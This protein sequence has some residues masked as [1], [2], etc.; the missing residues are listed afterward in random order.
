[1]RNFFEKA[2]NGAVS[3]VN[4]VLPALVF[5]VVTFI[6][7]GM[8][9]SIYRASEMERRAKFEVVAGDAADRIVNRF[10][11]HMSRPPAA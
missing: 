11:Q 2:E 7:L 6:G 4:R 5:L 3:S 9:L 10:Y 1:M 8:S